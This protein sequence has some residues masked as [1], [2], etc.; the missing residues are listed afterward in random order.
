MLVLWVAGRPCLAGEPGVSL[1]DIDDRTCIAKSELV[2]ALTRSGVVVAAA[3][4][5]PADAVHL[6]VRGPPESLVARLHGRGHDATTTLPA[7]TCE[8]SADVVA[9]FVV[10]ALSPAPVRELPRPAL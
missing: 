8:T 9:A 7:A 3:D 4:S 6:D 1:D 5:P 2:D 10:S